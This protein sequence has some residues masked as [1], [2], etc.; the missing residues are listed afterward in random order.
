MH[1][2]EEVVLGKVCNRKAQQDKNGEGNI[3]KGNGR[4]DMNNLVN[5]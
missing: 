2:T 4:L 5:I 3:V 1:Q